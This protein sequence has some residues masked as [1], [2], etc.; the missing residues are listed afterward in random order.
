MKALKLSSIAF[1]LTIGFNSLALANFTV[2]NL[3]IDGVIQPLEAV[4]GQTT[5]NIVN[6]PLTFSSA[7]FAPDSNDL[8]FGTFYREQASAGPAGTYNTFLFSTANIGQV[9]TSGDTESGF[10]M[11]VTN[12]AGQG[13]TLG[14]F[15]SPI[16][17]TPYFYFLDNT[18]LTTDGSPSINGYEP[19]IP[20]TASDGFLRLSIYNDGSFLY[21]SYSWD[22]DTYT[23]MATWMSASHFG[24]FYGTT[25]AGAQATAFGQTAV[26]VPAAAWLFAS[27][28]AGLGLTRRNRK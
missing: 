1:I 19:V 6:V 20:P 16:S 4:P 13:A 5:S 26:P 9:S 28:L 24:V 22:G 8:D 21:P 11:T 18:Y 23:S 17:G 25:P 2:D 27:A 15:N 12:T 10:G 14:V 3:Y 7:L